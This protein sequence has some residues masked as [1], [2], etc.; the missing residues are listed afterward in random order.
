MIKGDEKNYWNG[1][2]VYTLNGEIPF[3]TV[4]KEKK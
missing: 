3:W 1:L 4:T 2:R